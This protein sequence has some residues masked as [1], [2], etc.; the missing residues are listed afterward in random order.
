MGIACQT[1]DAKTSPF[2]QE[3]FE[4]QVVGDES[5]SLEDRH[6]LDGCLATY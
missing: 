6:G 2:P 1:S 4:K 5:H 3:L